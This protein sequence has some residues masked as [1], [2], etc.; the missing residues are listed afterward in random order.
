M[1]IDAKLL[2]QLV[3]QIQYPTLKNHIIANSIYFKFYTLK[4]FSMHYKRL[5]NFICLLI[6][7]PYTLAMK[8]IFLIH[9]LMYKNINYYKLYIIYKIIL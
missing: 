4:S 3:N 5:A 6:Y 2:N 7:I 8:F 9:C 1:H